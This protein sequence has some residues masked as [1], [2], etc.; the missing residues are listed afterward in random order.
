MKRTTKWL[1]LLVVL[2]VL[3]AACGGDSSTT[4]VAA[5]DTPDTTAAAPTTT[6]GS[7]D[8]TV[9]AEPA[10]PKT[11][12]IGTT[13]SIAGLDS[14]D[15]YAIHDWELLRNIGEA[16]LSFAPG[17]TDIVPGLASDYSVSDD[18]LVYTFNLRDDIFFG[19]GTELDANMYVDHLTRMLTLDGSGGVG[20]ALGTPFIESYRAVDDRTVEITLKDAFG[21]F[22]QV[23]TGAPYMPMHPDFPLDALVEFPDAPVYGVGVWMITEYVPGEQ[24]VLEPNPYYAGSAPAPKVDRIIIR[25]FNDAPTM[26]KAIETVKDGRGEIDIAWRTIG[27]PDLLAELEGVDGLT[28]GT[29]PGGGVRFMVINHQLAP[30][31][32]ADVRK[33]LAAL[34]D[35]DEISDRVYAGTAE[36]LYS[37]IPVGFLGANEA[38]DDVFGAPDI[39]AAQAFLTAAGYSETNKLQ[40][41]VAYPPEHYGGTAADLIQLLS[42]Q[43]EASGMIDVEIISQEWSTYIGAVIGGQDYAVS[44]LGWFFDYPDPD[45]YLAPF[46]N[47]G[48][49]GTMITDPDTNEP[50]DADAQALMD[51][52]VQAGTE[53]DVDARAALYADLQEKFAENVT[54]LPLFFLPEH[55]VYWDYISADDAAATIESLNIGPTFDLHY[56]LLDTSK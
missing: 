12:I 28:V 10:G 5:V 3:A 19:D 8:T 35:R 2:S 18:G 33:A 53:T 22:P 15:A 41:Q 39:P 52:L 31:D 7:T 25:Y 30:T 42:E 51:L 9:P 32:N 47:N 27:Q 40:L 16:L 46:M 29:V 37:M 20:G 56:E 43:Y 21:Y 24:T 45:N 55:V 11:I 34:V 38:F 36:P 1:V 4:T 48:G 17:T 23:V 50:I 14:A 26:A 44:L 54:T 49:L 6:T 13:D